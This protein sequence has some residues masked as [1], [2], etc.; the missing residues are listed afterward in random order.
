MNAVIEIEKN[1]GTRRAC[2]A[3]GIPK[4][5]LYRA[6]KPIEPKPQP[7]CPKVEL[8]HHRALSLA[9]ELTI[10]DLLDSERF[11]DLSPTEVYATLLDEGVYLCSIS[12]MYHI[13]R[14]HDQVKERRKQARHPLYVKPEL[15]ATG[16]NQVWSWDITKLH[17]PIKWNYYCLYVIIDIF[18]RMVVGWMVAHRECKELAIRLIQETC[19]K[20]GINYGQLAI[21]ADRGSSM[22]SKPVA[23]LLM[24][25]GV[26]KSH[27]RPRVSNDNPFSESQFKT[28]KYM[29]LFP[30]RF[31][32]IEDARSFCIR[33]FEWYNWEHHHSGVGLMTPGNVHYG[34]VQ[35]VTDRRQEALDVAYLTHP[36]RFVKRAPVAPK[37][38]EFVWINPP[39]KIIIT[40]GDA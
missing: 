4:S 34:K 20:Q 23:S 18:S 10:L 24:D 9:E 16:P 27:S 2:K 5:S 12:K 3:M 6:M 31:G 38:P 25:L 19:E 22:T 17:G 36:E 32:S 14:A 37:V 26:M 30:D 28:L 40:K 39:Q 29:P 11:Q 35:E 1:T 13:L 7:L 33:F 21:H 15:V 8:R